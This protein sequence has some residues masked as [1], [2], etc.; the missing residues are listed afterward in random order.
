MIYAKSLHAQNSIFYEAQLQET[1]LV[2]SDRRKLYQFIMA[3]A[4]VE[5][6]LPPTKN[7]DP[8]PLIE[9][10]S[11]VL[12]QPQ[13]EDQPDQEEIRPQD[14]VDQLTLTEAVNASI[15]LEMQQT[16]N[17]D[18][19]ELAKDLGAIKPQPVREVEPDQ[20]PTPPP[21]KLSFNNWLNAGISSKQASR[22]EIGT[23]VDLFITKKETLGNQAE[24]FSATK[25]AAASL[26][27]KEEI[28]TETLAKIYADQGN[29]S[30]AIS[31][32][33]SLGLKF[34]EKRT[35]FAGLIREL[36]KLKSD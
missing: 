16:G 4:I 1:A 13:Q 6:S 12:E 25:M 24:F 9:S 18:L 3:E 33:Q 28:V 29:Y 2:A 8:D 5:E 15:Q 34:P 7:V 35:F 31:A 20:K 11:P 19:G 22:R 17:Q 32:Y 26:V 14:A 30:K 23:L 10:T 27:D 21:S 36:E